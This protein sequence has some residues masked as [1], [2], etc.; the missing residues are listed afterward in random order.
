M[1]F[2]LRKCIYCNKYTMKISC[3]QCNQKTAF[4]HPAK[5]SLQDKY[6]KQR[7]RNKIKIM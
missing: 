4:M 7:I 2:L 5:F 6:L 3:L 1:K